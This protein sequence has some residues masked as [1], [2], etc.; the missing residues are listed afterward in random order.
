M[1]NVI[2]DICKKIQAKLS[3]LESKGLANTQEYEDLSD[4]YHN[5]AMNEITTCD[6][7]DALDTTTLI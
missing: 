1:I 4:E 2:S 3:K 5:L 6:F 7:C